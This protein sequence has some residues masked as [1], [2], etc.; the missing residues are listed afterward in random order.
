MTTQ[1]FILF[2]PISK[3]EVQQEAVAIGPLGIIFLRLVHR[4]LKL[5]SNLVKANIVKLC[6]SNYPF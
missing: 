5:S 6:H 1:V 4:H 3:F 2:C